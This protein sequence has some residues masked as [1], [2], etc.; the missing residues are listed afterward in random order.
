MPGA[1][2]AHAWRIMA[3]LLRMPGAVVAHAWRIMAQL[4]RMPGAVVAHACVLWNTHQKPCHRPDPS[5]EFD[6]ICS[7]EHLEL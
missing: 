1:G 4:L 5:R 2:V 7:R 3:Q 6:R